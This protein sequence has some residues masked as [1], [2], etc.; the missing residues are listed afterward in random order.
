MGAWRTD[1]ETL[2]MASRSALSSSSS[3]MRTPGPPASRLCP[4]LQ[5]RWMHCWAQAAGVGVLAAWEAGC[6]EQE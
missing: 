6:G 4:D 3:A 5:A 2:G 1:A